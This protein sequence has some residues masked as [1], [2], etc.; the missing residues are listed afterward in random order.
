MKLKHRV[1][2]IRL[3]MINSLRLSSAGGDGAEKDDVYGLCNMDIGKIGGG[4]KPIGP[5]PFLD[6][7]TAAAYAAVYSTFL[8]EF[9]SNMSPM[10]DFI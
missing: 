6:R 2:F 3:Q 8:S 9:R 1:K 4:Q 7:P 5:F 10:T